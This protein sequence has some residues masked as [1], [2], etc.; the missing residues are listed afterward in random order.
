MREYWRKDENKA[1]MSVSEVSLQLFG[2]S[3]ACILVLS[4]IFLV[5]RF[6]ACFDRALEQRKH[7]IQLKAEV[8]VVPTQAAERWRFESD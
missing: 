7:L 2:G 4:G 5:H 1:K 3:S 8:C 6:G